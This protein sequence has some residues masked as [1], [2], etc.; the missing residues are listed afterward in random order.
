MSEIEYLEI[1][2][3]LL[4][5]EKFGIRIGNCGDPFAA[6][7]AYVE[8]MDYLEE[9]ERRVE[10]YEACRPTPEE[11]ENYEEFLECLAEEYT[12]EQD[13]YDAAAESAR[14]YYDSIMQEELAWYNYCRMMGYE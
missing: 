14:D 8:Y 2:A 3:D 13:E 10:E 6:A 5:A 12:Y 7:D 9:L 11:V 1:L 4:Y